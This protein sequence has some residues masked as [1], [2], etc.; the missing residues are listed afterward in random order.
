[1]GNTVLVLGL[2]LVVLFVH[3]VIISAVEAHWLAQVTD[4]TKVVSYGC[5]FWGYPSNLYILLKPTSEC[6]LPIYYRL[7]MPYTSSVYV[8]IYLDVVLG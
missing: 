6:I 1:M 7:P 3:V 8:E 5:V 4:V 2:L